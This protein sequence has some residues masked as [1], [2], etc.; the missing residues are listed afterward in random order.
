MFWRGVLGYLPMNI[1]QALVGLF[2][3]V[4][5][6][7]WLAP[8]DYGVYALAFSGMSLIHTLLFIWM[9]AAM[10]RFYAPEAEGERL[11]DHF[12]TL[13][14]CW[15]GVAALLAALTAAFLLL[16]PASETLKLAVAAGAG[17]I[18]T[19]SLAKLNQERRRAA[20]DVR[21]AALMD[22]VQTVGGFAVGAGLIL[23]GLRGAAPIAG[24]GAGAAI[25]LV[26][27]LPAELRRSVGGRFEPAKARGYAAYGLPVSLS[28]I[29]ALALATTDRFILA[30]YVGE[31]AV[32]VYQAGYTLANRTLDVMFI[33]LGAAGTPALIMAF[34][35]GGADG[36]GEAARE[37]A[38]FML[39]LALPAALGL[40]LVAR[41]LAEVMVG[42]ALRGGA[43]LVTP[44]I[45]ASALFLGLTNGYTHQ[46][47]MLGRRTGLLLAAMSIPAAA[48][49]ALCFWLIPRFGLQGAV[50]ATTASYAIGLVAS[51]VIGR[52]AQPLPLPLA[53][54]AR[55]AAATAVMGL[56]VASL[57]A[58]GGAAELALKAGVG[59]AVYGLAAYVLDIAGLRSRGRGALAVLRA[60][61]AT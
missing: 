12:A 15:L 30:G 43:A 54:L 39:G 41:P 55:A 57:P 47:F 9:D 42:P 40:A 44:W 23:A 28:L 10:A 20:G 16:W 45:A 22:M 31:S 4:V 5:F 24:L 26:F 61:A 11:A 18:L 13:Y 59:A 19:R 2:S 29:L 6:T 27:V 34:E 35:R 32:G 60:R 49:V 38:G 48:N 8:A 3:I 52:L 53:A 36:L 58:L 21:G 25:V 50:W 14:R 46:A 33:W 51:A 1:V 7:R 37:Q 17:A 56:A